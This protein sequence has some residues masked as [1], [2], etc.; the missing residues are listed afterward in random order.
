L[1]RVGYVRNFIHR[2]IKPDNFL[3]G[4]GKCGNQVNVIDFGLAKKYRDLK[5]HLHIPCREGKNL[6]GTARY[7]SINTHLGRTRPDNL[8]SIAYTPMSLGCGLGSTPQAWEGAGPKPSDGL[9]PKDT[10]KDIQALLREHGLSLR[11]KDGQLTLEEKTGAGSGLPRKQR[12]I[13]VHIGP[14]PAGTPGRGEPDGYNLQ[15]KTRMND[16]DYTMVYDDAKTILERTHGIDTSR[17]ITRQNPRAIDLAVERLVSIHHELEPFAKYGYWAPR[18]F[19]QMILRNKSCKANTQARRALVQ[20]GQPGGAQSGPQQEAEPVAKPQKKRGRPRKVKT[21]APGGQPAIE[22]VPVVAAQPVPQ[23]EPALDSAPVAVA[24]AQPVPTVVAQPAPAV[25]IQP[26]P[27]VVVQPASR[28]RL[29]PE[30]M[31][32]VVVQ[33]VPTPPHG[34]DNDVETF[35]LE[36]DESDFDKTMASAAHNL[37]QMSIHANQ[38]GDK[39]GGTTEDDEDEDGGTFDMTLATGMPLILPPKVSSCDSA[40]PLATQ[41]PVPAA[42]ARAAAHPPTTS[43]ASSVPAP[44]T[45]ASMASSLTPPS[46]LPALRSSPRKQVVKD[47][48][49][50]PAR[51]STSPFAAV[52]NALAPNARPAHSKHTT[53]APFG[54]T[55]ATNS[56]SDIVW[57]GLTISAADMAKIRSAAARQA[58]GQPPRIASIHKDLINKLAANPEYDPASEPLPIHNLPAAPAPTT[59]RNKSHGHGRAATTAAAA[60]VDPAATPLAPADTPPAVENLKPQ[61]KSKSKSKSKP[62]AKAKAKPKAKPKPKPK[63]TPAP[64]PEPEPEPEPES[65]SESEPESTTHDKHALDGTAP[66]E[67]TD[68]DVHMEVATDEGPGLASGKL[69][70]VN[71]QETE[72]DMR[73]TGKGKAAGGEVSVQATTRAAT[74]RGA[75]KTKTAAPASNAP[76]PAS[77]PRRTTAPP[78]GK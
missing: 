60:A 10:V 16:D 43:M 48:P 52:A 35:D 50:P 26:A 11:M 24:A 9:M 44:E 32:A 47:D 20:V 17:A 27:T 3:M 18:A 5:T 39:P 67:G 19:F 30:N 8:G 6:T 72:G 45:D 70:E 75:N 36:L 68:G 38:I 15:E 12:P 59:A 76:A 37:S 46:A 71:Q 65:E 22:G 41:V 31:S 62:K 4:T 14:K 63:S 28:D 55:A 69:G 1:L 66:G 49:P 21:L 33:P 29:A 25:A 53:I 42:S 73:T 77:R 57:H 54:S 51:T 40:P 74:N 13:Y 64:A 2:D 78:K 34:D 58:E 56:D 7:T 61:P 23:G